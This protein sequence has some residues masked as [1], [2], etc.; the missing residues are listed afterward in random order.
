[1]FLCVAVISSVGWGSASYEFTLC[2]CVVL[3]CCVFCVS[4]CLLCDLELLG[5]L[6][7]FGVDGYVG[8]LLL[9]FPLFYVFLLLLLDNV[10]YI[11]SSILTLFLLL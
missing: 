10:L 5:M 9:S 8:A 1:M 3:L 7:I 4:V 11:I 2:L 6:L